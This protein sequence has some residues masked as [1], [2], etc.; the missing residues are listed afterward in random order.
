MTTPATPNVFVGS[1]DDTSEGGLFVST[2]STNLSTE[3]PETSSDATIATPDSFTG[4]TDNAADG[5]LFTD[6]NVSS[7]ADIKITKIIAG[8]GLVGTSL[9]G[10]VPTLNIDS[11]VV[12]LTG[13]QTLTNK[14]IDVDNNTVSNIEVDNFK[15]GVLDTDLTTVSATDNT[16]A[17]AKAI[18]TYVDAQV[19]AQDLDLQGDLGGVISIDL[20]SEVLDIVGGT[21]ID[22]SGSA[23]TLTVSIDSTVTTLTDTQ[24]LTNK[25]LSFPTISTISNTGVITLPTSTDTLIGRSTT[26]TLTNKTIDVDNNT[27]SN[28]EVDN[29][30]GTA[31]VTETEGIGSNDNDTSLPTSAAVKDYVDTQITSQDLDFQAD[32]GGALSIDLDSEVL[33]FTGGTGID[34]SGSGNAVTFAIDSTVTTLSGTQTLT[35]KTIDIAN[36]TI[37][38]A[39][40]DLSDASSIDAATL[41]SIDST[42]FLRSDV[43]DT[44][45][46]GDLS[47][48][49]NVKALFGTG[50]DLEIYSTG[51]FSIIQNNTTASFL[52]RSNGFTFT[53]AAMN[54][55][56]F[57]ATSNS[58]TYLYYDG[59]SKISTTSTGATINGALTVSG[60][61]TVNGTTTTI[62]TQTL[63][64]EDP[65]IFL[66]NNNDSTDVVDIGF[67]GL[68]DTSGTQDL[69][70]GLFRDASDDKFKL[71]KSLQ[72]E[73]TSTVDTGG[74]GYTVATLVAD[75]E[76]NVTGNLT[77]NVTGDVTGAVTTKTSTGGVLELQKSGT[78]VLEDDELG[79]IRF[80]APDTT[81]AAPNSP[82][83]KSFDIV[84]S[85]TKGFTAYETPTKLSFKTRN[86][87]YNASTQDLIEMFS[88]NPDGS[89]SLP[90]DARKIRFHSYVD[91]PGSSDFD[92]SF[93]VLG[94]NNGYIRNSGSP[95]TDFTYN[96]SYQAD[97]HLFYTESGGGATPTYQLA[98]SILNQINAGIH[99]PLYIKTYSEFPFWIE[100]AGTGTGNLYL[101]SSFVA[102]N[103]VDTTAAELNMLDGS[104]KSTTSITIDD[105]DAFVIIDDTTTKQIPASDISSYVKGTGTTTPVK[106]AGLETI[107]I[108]ASTMRPRLTDGLTIDQIVNPANSSTS[109]PEI[110]GFKCNSTDVSSAKYAEFSVALPKSWNGGTVTSR[111]H[112]LNL[113]ATTDNI[114]NIF[115]AAT[116]FK[117]A[118]YA[119]ASFGT[120]IEYT[121]GTATL[122]ANA[123]YTFDSTSS[124]TINN[125]PTGNGTDLIN[126][127]L[128]SSAISSA[129]D[130][131]IV[132]VQLF[133]TTDAKNDA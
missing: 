102:S 44:K 85:A 54:K 23:N 51:A 19:T 9:E 98:M 105:A 107:W 30:K 94:N 4:S 115:L 61:L 130:F 43:A 52:F 58:S 96:I 10:P 67:Y 118:Y 86:N 92:E 127:Q 16:L 87:L 78:S 121:N 17:S 18:K 21:G 8:T 6:V 109:F 100:D 59:I 120:A 83:L 7:V 24:T 13:I 131:L 60:D 28:I 84:A 70:A 90:Y 37:T 53:N 14:T 65:L 116:A 93:I 71:F 47:F 27:V 125:T 110:E 42:S 57:S 117:N 126:F 76:G 77:G 119:S 40:T 48:D 45:T 132:G 122:A 73:P 88:V 33:T 111:L 72:T 3:A 22:T 34:T 39:S 41:D 89:I 129:V 128:S 38:I 97:Q 108:P 2:S 46:A 91:T 12:T 104:A 32:T 106:E 25:T 113:V 29:F 36:N 63:S 103:R 133:F 15:S 124:I 66:A 74:T 69:Y 123:Y 11:T 82:S 56:M 75:I 101:G 35:N 79:L 112:V 99:S 62:D 68:Y 49:D 20:D 1:T 95:L 31:I 114:E 5:S 80:Y 26:D 50:S 55:P 64:V 81:Y